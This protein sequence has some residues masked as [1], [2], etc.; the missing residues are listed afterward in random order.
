MN[1]TTT[2][3]IGDRITVDIATTVGQDSWIEA[4]G[5]TVFEIEV[6]H[7]PRIWTNTVTGET[8]SDSGFGR[9]VAGPLTK[10]PVV[11]DILFTLDCIVG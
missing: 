10:F 8:D 7:S 11:N 9:I 4:N 3:K 6:T 2:H 1:T 5:S